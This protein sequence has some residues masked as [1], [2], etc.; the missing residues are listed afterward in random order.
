VDSGSSSN[1]LPATL[2]GLRGVR[3]VAFHP[4]GGYF[5]ATHRGGDIWY[6]DTAG[7]AWL[8][9]QGD[10]GNAHVPGSV[11]VPATG[12]SVMSEPRS[13]TVSLSG[14]VLIACNDAGFI[15]IIRNVLPPPPPPV[16][17]TPALTATGMELQ[18]QSAAGRW[19]FLERATTLDAAA[20]QPLAT[21]P[22]AGALTEFTDPGAA[23]GQRAFYR[24]RSFRDWPN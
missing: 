4:L 14:D 20:W 13:V 5:V 6:V 21:L 17:E 2:V 22:S 1:G 7:K 10:N 8:F 24:L 23:S 19:Y 16:W 18:W 15:R 9:V 12:F 11:P 3:G